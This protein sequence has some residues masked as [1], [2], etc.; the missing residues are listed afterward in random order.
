MLSALA[1]VAGLAL[2]AAWY[3]AGL[4]RLWGRAGRGAGVSIPRAGAFAGG[5]AA[6]ALALSPPVDGLADASLSAHM[7]QHVALM[8]VAAPLLVAGDPLRVFPWA[9]GAPLR[10]RLARV[11]TGPARHAATLSGVA[12]AAVV[13]VVVLWGWH[14]PV[15]YDAAAGDAR[16]HAV[17]HATMLGAAVAFWAVLPRA[18]VAAPVLVA[19]VGAAVGVMVAGAALGLLMT[20]AA[21]PWF[22]HYAG[23][24]GALAD[25]QA[26]GAIMWGVGGGFYAV[27]AAALLVRL[28][29]D[30][31]PSRVHAPR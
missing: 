12:V 24:P 2:L 23:A 22:A 10:H 26:A 30:R 11:L 13:H 20:F 4:R 18:R 1:P 8:A 25:Q 3:V 29:G 27:A 5:I 21:R 19:A 9:F 15:L 7:G 17:E 14:V 6:T 16:L 31:G 28:L